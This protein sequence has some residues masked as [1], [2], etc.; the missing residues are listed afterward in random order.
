MAAGKLCTWVAGDIYM[1][2]KAEDVARRRESK[3]LI[4]TG[5][6]K[7]ESSERGMHNGYCMGRRQRE[8][9]WCVAACDGW[10]DG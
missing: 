9:W 10:G 5:R 7:E 3:I 2:K 1:Y 8:F 4:A 6:Q